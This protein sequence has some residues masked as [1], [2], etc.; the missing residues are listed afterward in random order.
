MKSLF[1]R[2]LVSIWVAMA[3]LVGVFAVIHAWTFPRDASQRWRRVSSRTTELRALQA[4]D[5]R[6]TT[7]ESSCAE[8]LEPLDDRDPSV[9]I[10]K[11]G[12]RIMGSEIEGATDVEAAAR[13]SRSNAL[14]AEDDRE[15]SALYLERA[16][17]GPYVVVSTQRHPSPWMFFFFPETLPLRLGAIFVLTGSLA[18]ALARWL[19]RPLRTLRAATQRLAAGDL[20]VR[21]ERELTRADG[22]SMALGREMDRMAERIEALLEAQKR[23]L[24]DVS[25]ELRSPLARLALAL[26]L[27]RRKAPPDAEKALCRI[28]LEAS[29]LDAMIGELLALSRLEAGVGLEKTEPVDLRGVLE[30]VVADV[31]FE[32]EQHGA[33]VELAPGVGLEVDGNVELLR[34]AF[35][36][37]LRNAARHT[38]EGTA[39]EVELRAGADRMAHLS[40]RDH[41][42][43]VPEDALQKIFQPFYRV[44]EDRARTTGGTGIGLAIAERS[45]ALHG[46]TIEARNAT[47]GGL[48]IDM[49]L[50]LRSAT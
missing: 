33:R 4:L 34:R 19:S 14:K 2:L 50:P 32:A 31:A 11:D 28:E 25:H 40:I 7:K 23:L 47:G 49:C 10:F 6:R 45:I 27:V 37:V 30:A 26:E 43:G 22:E 44:G 17:D 16:L 1:V 29:R 12:V 46:G 8:I 3:V 36:N 42:A 38:D 13:A 21:V 20:S 39:V 35:E 15:L 18:F 41:G 5:C 48:I 9:T 24:R